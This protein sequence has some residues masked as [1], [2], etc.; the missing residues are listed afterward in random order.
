MWTAAPR[1]PSPASIRLLSPFVKGLGWVSMA[2]SFANAAPI[3]LVRPNSVN[4]PQAF[5]Y[6]LLWILILMP[7]AGLPYTVLQAL[8]SP[9]DALMVFLIT[10]SGF[11]LE[12]AYYRGFARDE[13]IFSLFDIFPGPSFGAAS[14]SVDSIWG[15][16]MRVGWLTN[17][18]IGSCLVD[19]SLRRRSIVRWIQFGWDSGSDDLRL[20]VHTPS[21]GSLSCLSV[22]PPGLTNMVIETFSF[23]E[24][25]ARRG[26]WTS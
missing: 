15:V 7:V 10:F 12:F 13:F 3:G 26:W 16:A 5:S 20:Q 24:N 1:R 18:A 11:R 4:P 17:G 23:G 9:D 6:G 8:R 25:I 2:S 14:L 22:R 21:F 19:F